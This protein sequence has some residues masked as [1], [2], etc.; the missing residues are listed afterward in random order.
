MKKTLGAGE[1]KKRKSARVSFAAAPET[2]PIPVL[3][4]VVQ[5]SKDQPLEDCIVGQRN[6]DYMNESTSERWTSQFT[7][8]SDM[9]ATILPTAFD[10]SPI[11]SSRKHTAVDGLNEIQDNTLVLDNTSASTID[12]APTAANESASTPLPVNFNE[13]VSVLWP[14]FCLNSRL[15]D[16]CQPDCSREQAGAMGIA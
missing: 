11:F 6:T 16:L 5:A 3:V 7:S 15:Q 12:S 4:D 13:C 9:Y 8:T 14:T 1:K 2:I 10:V